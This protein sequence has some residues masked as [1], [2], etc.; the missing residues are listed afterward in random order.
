[1]NYL[2]QTS[3]KEKKNT[4][5]GGA[6]RSLIGR[7]TRNAFREIMGWVVSGG[8]TKN[9]NG[10]IIHIYPKEYIM[11]Y[12]I[13]HYEK[14]KYKIPININTYEKLEEKAR[15]KYGLEFYFRNFVGWE[16]TKNGTPYDP[17]RNSTEKY[18]KEFIMNYIVEEVRKKKYK[19]P[20]DKELYEQL[21][22]QGK[23]QE[24]LNIV[25]WN[26]YNGKPYN[27]NTYE[28]QIYPDTY[29][30]NYIIQEVN[31]EKHKHLPIKKELYNKLKLEAQEKKNAKN[32]MR[33]IRVLY[34]PKKSANSANSANPAFANFFQQLREKSTKSSLGNFGVNS[35]NSAK[36]GFVNLSANSAK[37]SF[38]NLGANSAKSSF[39]NLRANSAN[40]ANAAFN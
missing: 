2:F 13:D 39:V 31:K 16:V 9:K 30:M 34:E 24:F 23:E 38:V 40:S 21:K 12:V 37:S 1:M 7:D 36:S 17:I 10:K 15:E 14:Y 28:Y 20:I 8:I 19:I 6:F 29:I 22:D 25:G 18:P 3:Y 5:K 27:R 35:A 33:N 26:I 32:K 11:E 4:L